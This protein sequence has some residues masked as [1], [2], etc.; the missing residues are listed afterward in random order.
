MS[1]T[2]KPRFEPPL[3]VSIAEYFINFCDTLPLEMLNPTID[4]G[5]MRKEGWSQ[6][7]STLVPME[8]LVIVS[9]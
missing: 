9:N 3:L 5:G 6:N 8:T 7:C 4:V 2:G 1:R